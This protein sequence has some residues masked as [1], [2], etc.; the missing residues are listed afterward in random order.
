MPDKTA[1]N[2]SSVRTLVKSVTKLA[3][4]FGLSNNA[5]YRWI[6]VNRIPGSYVVQVANFY[7]V[8]VKDLIHLTGSDKAN[9]VQVTTKPKNTLAELLE[10]YRGNKTLEE[11]CAT[12]G[13]TV[14][15]GKLS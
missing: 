3:R 15:S 10:V 2:L 7:D 4:H 14:I 13:I 9:V 5:I 1:A 12:L 6:A 11:A 8:E